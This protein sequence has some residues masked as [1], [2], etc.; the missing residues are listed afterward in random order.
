MPQFTLGTPE[1]L[2]EEPQPTWFARVKLSSMALVL[3]VPA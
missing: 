1:A 3:V 2:V